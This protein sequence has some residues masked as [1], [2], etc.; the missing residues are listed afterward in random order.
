MVEQVDGVEL[1]LG[2]VAERVHQVG[3]VRPDALGRPAHDVD[4]PL[5]HEILRALFARVG[6]PRSGGVLELHRGARTHLTGAGSNKRYT[7]G[8]P[9][10]TLSRLQDKAQVLIEF[11][12]QVANEKHLQ[13]KKVILTRYFTESAKHNDAS[14]YIETPALRTRSESYG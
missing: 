6:Q 9:P 12:Q 2:A 8:A 14:I 13:Q 4:I 7:R 1:L 11:S 5:R 10:P 3:L